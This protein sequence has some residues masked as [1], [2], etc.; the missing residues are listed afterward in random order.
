[1]HLN[2]IFLFLFLFYPSGGKKNSYRKE[3]Y[4]KLKLWLFGY[5]LHY[6]TN[7]NYYK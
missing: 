4:R 6:L 1:M 7:P 3:P 2:L 5:F